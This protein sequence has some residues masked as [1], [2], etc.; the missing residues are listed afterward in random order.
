MATAA[1]VPQSRI[2]V[3]LQ[4]CYLAMSVNPIQGT[5]L[6]FSAGDG[7]VARLTFVSTAKGKSGIDMLIAITAM[8]GSGWPARSSADRTRLPRPHGALADACRPAR[9]RLTGS[10]VPIPGGRASDEF[11][12]EPSL[13]QP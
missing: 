4:S 6:F 3:Q 1:D 8:L 7:P 11:A 2:E 13:P 12:M 10:M 9:Y 5:S